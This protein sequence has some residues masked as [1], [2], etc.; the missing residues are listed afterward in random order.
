[1]QFV[2]S[3]SSSG[4]GAQYQ[5]KQEAMDKMLAAMQTQSSGVVVTNV[6]EEYADHSGYCTSTVVSCTPPSGGRLTFGFEPD[7]PAIIF[8]EG[9][10]SQ[11][12]TTVSCQVAEGEAGFT[13]TVE[14]WYH[15]S[16]EDD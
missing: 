14:E 15:Y 1:M 5:I 13:F 9:G 4:L 16:D 8:A 11:F 7:P 6:A 12:Q 10:D 3:A 2:E